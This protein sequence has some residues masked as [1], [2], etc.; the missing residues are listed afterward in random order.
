[1]QHKLP[2]SAGRQQDNPLEPDPKEVD[3]TYETGKVLLQRAKRIREPKLHDS[4]RNPL[5]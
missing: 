1:M 4:N 2:C 5:E 3:A